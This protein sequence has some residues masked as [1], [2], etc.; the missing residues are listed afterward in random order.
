MVKHTE[1]A[2]YVAAQKQHSTLTGKDANSLVA[3]PT[4]DADGTDGHCYLFEVRMDDVHVTSICTPL[5][6]AAFDCILHEEDVRMIKR[7]LGV[8]VTWNFTD[9]PHKAIIFPHQED[10]DREEAAHREHMSDELP[11]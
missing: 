7:E 10:V 6:P 9:K 2:A 5:G 8:S 1:L 11:F 3:F 4:L